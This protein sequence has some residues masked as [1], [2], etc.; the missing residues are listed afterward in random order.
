[1]HNNYTLSAILTI[2]L[3]SNTYSALEAHICQLTHQLFIKFS[4][5]CGISIISRK[6][7][8]SKQRTHLSGFVE[9]EM[10]GDKARE[11]WKDQGMDVGL[12]YVGWD[13]DQ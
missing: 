7:Q 12:G 3:T 10:K 9:Q 1:M 13:V 5:K 11:N 4:N 2:T 6:V 8:Y